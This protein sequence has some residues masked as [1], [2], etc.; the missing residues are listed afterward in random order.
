MH[1]ATTDTE[2]PALHINY[3]IAPKARINLAELAEVLESVPAPVR[4]RMPLPILATHLY[5]KALAKPTLIEEVEAV[6]ADET[7]RRARP[8]MTVT[9]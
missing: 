2:A 8:S 1:L 7:A 9:R 5:G 3:S 6:L 4:H